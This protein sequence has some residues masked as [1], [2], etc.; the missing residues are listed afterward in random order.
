MKTSIRE[1]NERLLAIL[2]GAKRDQ[3]ILNFMSDKDE[4]SSPSPLLN[5]KKIFRDVSTFLTSLYGRAPRPALL[6]EIDVY[7][8]GCM[9]VRWEEGDTYLLLSFYDDKRVTYYGASP[10]SVIKGQS[11]PNILEIR[12]WLTENTGDLESAKEFEEKLKSSVQDCLNDKL[13]ALIK[14]GEYH[15]ACTLC[16]DERRIQGVPIVINPL[17]DGVPLGDTVVDIVKEDNESL[18]RFF[19]KESLITRYHIRNIVEAVIER[20]KWVTAETNVTKPCNTREEE[21]DLTAE[22]NRLFEGSHSHKLVELLFVATHPTITLAIGDI[23]DVE[24]FPHSCAVY[25]KQ[26]TLGIIIRHIESG[27][28]EWFESKGPDSFESEKAEALFRL[29]KERVRAWK[30]QVKDKK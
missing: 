25:E 22:A 16:Y 23:G 12:L 10:R 29:F 27:L 15:Q 2:E 14:Q 20:R 7:E 24:V 4:T 18:L 26:P 21:T 11:L 5:K 6:P 30:N 13:S 28:Q 9:D 3:D 17:V 8:N 1:H 19:H